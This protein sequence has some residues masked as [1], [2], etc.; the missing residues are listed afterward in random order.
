M[1]ASNQRHC[2]PHQDPNKSPECRKHGKAPIDRLENY[3]KRCEKHD[4]A[5]AVNEIAG[6]ADAKESFVRQDIPSGFGIVPDNQAKWIP[7]L[8]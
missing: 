7:K 3:V 2:K 5:C 6:D 4:D 1:H 8:T